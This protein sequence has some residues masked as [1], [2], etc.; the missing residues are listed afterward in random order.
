[1]AFTGLPGTGKSALA[2]AVAS[3]LACPAFSVDPL[4]AVLLRAGIT[5]E[6]RSDYAAYDLAA[7]CA[8]EQVRRGLPAVVDAVN[9]L[10]RLQRWWGDIAECHGA[11]FRLIYTVCSDPELHRSR[12]ETRHRNLD[13][14]PY[15]PAWADVRRRNY[16]PPTLPHLE[17]DAVESLA[18]NV[19]RILTY[20]LGDGA[21]R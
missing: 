18:S 7:F 3:A 21:E 14:F 2:E 13:G 15:E 4:E 6:Q 1:M 17:V 9:A 8:Q 20:V 16:S 19:D 12:L 11:A 10:P 5:R